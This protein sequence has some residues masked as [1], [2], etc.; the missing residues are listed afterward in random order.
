MIRPDSS[1]WTQPKACAS[2]WHMLGADA[3]LGTLGDQ[4]VQAAG[5]WGQLPA[6]VSLTKGDALFPRLVDEDSAEG[7]D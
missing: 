3:A 4:R 5:Q 6:G 2:L 7:Q 1:M